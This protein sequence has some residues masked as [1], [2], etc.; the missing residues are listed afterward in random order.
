[1]PFCGRPRLGRFLP[2]LCSIAFRAASVSW[3]VTRRA[4]SRGNSLGFLTAGSLLPAGAA[5]IDQSGDVT[6]SD[7]KT[8]A[9]TPTF[10][11]PIN[12][13]RSSAA[14]EFLG[15]PRSARMDQRH[16]MLHE[17]RR[18]LAVVPIEPHLRYVPK[19]GCCVHLRVEN[20][21]GAIRTHGPR[22]RKTMPTVT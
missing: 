22:I 12:H 19:R 1:M 8:T 5:C 16:A 21:P 17:V 2:S 6:T 13:R 11:S 9:T 3:A 20:A 14:V 4:L 15:R 10:E 7:V 18:R